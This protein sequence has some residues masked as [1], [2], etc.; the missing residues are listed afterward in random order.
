MKKLLITALLSLPLI[1]LA[2]P[3]ASTNLLTNGSFDSDV[4]A[5]GSWSI[6]SNLTGWTGGAYGVELRDAI[7]GTAYDGGNFIELDT[8][9]NSSI[10]QT[11]A[12]NVGQTYLLS[13]V[14]AARPDNK[15]AASDG[16]SWSAGNMS[17]V[18]FGQDTNTAWTM[19]SA[20]FVATGT[21]TT[22][23][24]KAMGTSDSFGTSLDDVSVTAVPEPGSLALLGAGFSALAWTARRR[25]VKRA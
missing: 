19:M 1:A 10:S 18:A 5:A 4:Q 13:F 25:A 14:Y 23:S 6:K 21:S 11:F 2:G 8:T 12:T 9:A 3:V 16:I 17:N 22:L 7:A 20:S 15:G 24:F